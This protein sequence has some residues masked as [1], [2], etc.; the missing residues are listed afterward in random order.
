MLEP[1]IHLYFDRIQYTA[2][3]FRYCRQPTNLRRD[4]CMIKFILPLAALLVPVF[5]LGANEI[6]T[7]KRLAID[8]FL[9]TFDVDLQRSALN[10]QT[11]ESVITELENSDLEITQPTLDEIRVEASKVVN[12]EFDLEARIE[13]DLYKMIDENFTAAEL[14]TLTTLLSSPAWQ[15]FERFEQ[16]FESGFRDLVLRHSRELRDILRQRITTILRASQ[17]EAGDSGNAEPAQ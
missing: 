17:Q 6:P 10:A 13:T 15:K 9:A 11:I 4:T 16:G 2:A 5:A 1:V 3:L 7:Q 14:E 12:D 8:Q